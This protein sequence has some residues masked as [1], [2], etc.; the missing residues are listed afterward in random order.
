[1]LGRGKVLTARQIAERLEVSERTIY[2]DINDLVGSGVPIDGEAG[3]G[4]RMGRDYQVPPM[5]FDPQELQ[6]LAF[7]VRVAQV[8]GDAKMSDAAERAL[9]KIDAALPPHLRPD[10]ESQGVYVPGPAASEMPDRTGTRIL[11]EL[12]EAIGARRRVFL[13]Y[14]DV[15]GNPTERIVW[16]LSLAFWRTS[17]TLGGWCELRESFRNFRIDRVQRVE[18]LS[19]QIPDMPGRRLADYI[20]AMEGG[21]PEH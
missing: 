6:A 18:T 13:H 9:A 1:M 7:G 19:S 16:P 3:V 17:W 10:L 8:H 12:R 15:Q 2:R 20:R 21:P 4:Y 14:A 11:G 5:M